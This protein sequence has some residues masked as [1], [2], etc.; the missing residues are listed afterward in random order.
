M[1]CCQALAS[2]WLR[3]LGA[4][5]IAAVIGGASAAPPALTPEDAYRQ[6]RQQGRLADVTIDGDLDLGRLLQGG[7][8]PEQPAGWRLD[9]VQLRGKLILRTPTPL[10]LRI[11][12][13]HLQGGIDFRGCELDRFALHH[14][15]ISGPVRIEDC[16]LT[17]PIIRFDFNQFERELRLHRVIMTHRPSFRETRFGARAELLACELATEERPSRAIS[18]RSASFL[19]P[20]LFN[21]SVFHTNA[22]FRSALFA[23]DAAFLNVC[24]PAGA[25]FRNVHFRGDAEFRFCTLGRGDFGDR[26]NLTLFAGRADFRG[27]TIDEARFR[28]TDFRGESSF[29]ETRFGSGGASFAY[30]NLAGR[31]DF[32]G[33]NSTG[34]LDL[35]HAYFPSLS[36]VWLEIRDAVLAAT[37]DLRTLAALHA[38]AAAAGDTAGRLELEY[39]LERERFRLRQAR[40]LPALT[41]APLAFVEGLVARL[42]G[43][44][45][46][47]V[48]GW[49]TGYGTK[50]ERILALAAA[51]WLI[52]WFWLLVMPGNP[53][54]VKQQG[55]EQ[56]GGA[57]LP[58]YRPLAAAGQHRREPVTRPE[59]LLW[60]AQLAFRLL[61]KVGP[62]DLRLA[63][64]C[65][66]AA[67]AG[68]RLRLLRYGLLSLWLLG[69]LLLVLLALTLANTSPVINQLVGELFPI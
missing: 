57:A 44:T 52:T 50:L 47:L 46:W 13:A 56:D 51:A 23:D 31:T 29:V 39:L 14:S 4:L 69:S 11:G 9:A 59:R 8:P 7:E 54:R 22:D 32:H 12:N 6:L 35:T 18:F 15:V 41:K 24:M 55:R 43:I 66:E 33:L 40:P 1:V 67:A 25:A 60:S 20:A 53:V 48:W 21:N 62:R 61:F 65:E 45:E 5:S 64:T 16:N 2:R 37:P 63:V 27:C 30:A 10:R 38:R 28:F 49:P 17:G 68:R 36:F 58:L 42:V 3:R 19:G 26:D 34:P